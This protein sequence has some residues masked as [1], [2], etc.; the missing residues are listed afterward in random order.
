MAGIAWLVAALR[1]AGEDVARQRQLQVTIATLGLG[2][3]GGMARILPGGLGGPAWV[4]VSLVAGAAVL[5]VYA[6]LA[7]RLFVGADVTARAFWSSR[8]R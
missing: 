4:G 6:V 1:R 8:F 3:A 7:Q 5:A 2:I